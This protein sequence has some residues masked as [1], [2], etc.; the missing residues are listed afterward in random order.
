[1]NADVGG[2]G[3]KQEVVM[4]R[5][6]LVSDSE[7][8][9]FLLNEVLSA[10]PQVQIIG[11]AWNMDEAVRIAG[12]LR[13][14]LIVISS[15]IAIRQDVVSLAERVYRADSDAVVVVAAEFLPSHFRNDLL[16]VCAI[17]VAAP[18]HELPSA[19]EELIP[20]L[21]VPA[22]LVQNKVP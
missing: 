19:L 20:D 16:E 12:E 17:P 9:S 11:N 2:T 7:G 5:V 22:S 8:M 18:L 4:A 3:R 10:H 14:D 15:G 6:L 13:P 1:M 21:R